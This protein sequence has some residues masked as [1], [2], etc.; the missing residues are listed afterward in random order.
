MCFMGWAGLYK[1]WLGLAHCKYS[2]GCTAHK[3]PISRQRKPHLPITYKPNL[4]LKKKKT[5]PAIHHI[6]PSPNTPSSTQHALKALFFRIYPHQPNHNLS[7]VLSNADVCRHPIT[8]RDRQRSP[9][10]SRAQTVHFQLPPTNQISNIKSISKTITP[11][12]VD[13]PPPPGQKKT[14]Q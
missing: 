2:T 6:S 4:K 11:T 1:T 9:I 12:T 14:S 8:H 5:Y 13:H 7:L 3:M 10:C